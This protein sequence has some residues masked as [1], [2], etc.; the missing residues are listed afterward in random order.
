MDSIYENIDEYN[1]QKN[2]TH[3]SHSMIWL[4]MC[5]GTK[6]FEPIA[7][8]L[9][10]RSRK[11]NS[12]FVFITQWYFSVSKNIRPNCTHYFIIKIPNKRELTQIAINHSS[13]IDFRDFM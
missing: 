5:L 11:I 4:L 10:T 6:K 3:C 7:T 2:A 1:P 9:F 12:Y 8:E 13:D